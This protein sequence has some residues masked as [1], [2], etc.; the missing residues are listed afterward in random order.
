MYVERSEKW[1]AQILLF[2][3]LKQWR[4]V[5]WVS[6]YVLNFIPTFFY[7]LHY[8]LVWIRSKKI[9]FVFFVFLLSGASF[10]NNSNAFFCYSLS[11]FFVYFFRR[12]LVDLCTFHSVIGRSV[13]HFGFDS[14]CVWEVLFVL[15]ISHLFVNE[16][17]ILTN[18]SL[19]PLL[20]YSLD[21]MKC[22]TWLEFEFVVSFSSMCHR[23]EETRFVIFFISFEHCFFFSINERSLKSLQSLFFR[24]V[25]FCRILCPFK[26]HWHRRKH[27][28]LFFLSSFSSLRFVSFSRLPFNFI[29]SS[30]FS[31]R[32]RQFCSAL[33]SAYQTIST[34]IFV[35]LDADKND[36]KRK[37]ERKY[38]TQQHQYIVSFAW[39]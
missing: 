25:F 13:A 27:F 22:E 24:S 20:V 7:L 19:L 12:R 4:A 39:T 15:A 30:F 3:A 37:E 16:R 6:F 29:R 8:I 38:Q 34:Y 9:Y 17:I 2:E 31:F 35:F 18:F 28:D 26:T 23:D 11:F 32:F 36:R 5:T 33:L 21:W 14:N 1:D 10:G